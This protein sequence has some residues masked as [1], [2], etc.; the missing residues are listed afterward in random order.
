MRILLVSGKGGVGKTS[1][2]AATGVR[3]SE[4]GYY[5]SKNKENCKNGGA[6][7]GQSYTVNE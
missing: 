6:G 2:S 4:L 7:R 5:E 3:L 1:L